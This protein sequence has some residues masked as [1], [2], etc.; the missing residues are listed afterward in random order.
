MCSLFDI[1]EFVAAE[2]LPPRPEVCYCLFL[3]L[4]VLLNQEPARHT[5]LLDLCLFWLKTG[6]F[7]LKCSHWW[8]QRVDLTHVQVLLQTAIQSYAH[9][10]H[11]GNIFIISQ[12]SILKLRNMS[13]IAE[14][15][16]I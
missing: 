15:G 6:K 9:F 10:N 14:G 12:P 4:F 13:L 7:R 1:L 8:S 2:I 3:L 16:L 11:L 5:P